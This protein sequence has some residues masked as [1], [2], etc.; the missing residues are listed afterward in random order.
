MKPRGACSVSAGEALE[1]A[2]FKGSVHRAEAQ[3]SAPTGTCRVGSRSL[4]SALPDSALIARVLDGDEQ[5]FVALVDRY[6]ASLF[7]LARSFV[8]T[9]AVA[10]EVAQE[11]W[12]VVIERLP[13]FES[14]SSLKTWIFRILANRARTRGTRER[15]S[16]PFSA[17]ESEGEPESAVDPARFKGNERWSM[18]PRRWHD[19][20]PEQV[21]SRKE[22]IER[23]EVALDRLPESQRVVV[24]LRDVEGLSADEVC[25]VL[26]ISATNQRVL[27]HRARARLRAALEEYVD[28][29]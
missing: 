22:A 16:V 28:G 4:Q 24:I 18:P 9:A 17:F 1:K 7:R 2:G 25:S 23:L 3:V 29:A 15:R 26:E 19:D 14:R 20:T 5:G 8:P 6:G 11:A 13:S 21:L 27:L 10:E 12:L